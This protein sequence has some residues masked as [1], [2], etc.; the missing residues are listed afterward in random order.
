MTRRVQGFEMAPRLRSQSTGG[1]ADEWFDEAA[2]LRYLAARRA[3]VGQ[4]T[5]GAS[6]AIFV[7]SSARRLARNF[8]TKSAP[9]PT[10]RS[11]SKG[12]RAGRPPL[13]AT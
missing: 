5:E 1:A 7:P 3:K 12:L 11:P 2:R 8:L 6:R 4:V 10:P 9:D 13:S